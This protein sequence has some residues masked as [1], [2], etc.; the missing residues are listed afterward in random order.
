KKIQHAA[1]QI[2]LGRFHLQTALRIKRRQVVKENLVA[3]DF[4][5]LKIDGFDF[6]QREI[7]FAV[8][9]RAH[10]AGD[11]VAGAQV[12]LADLRRG[13]VD[14][15][16]PGKIVVFRSAQESESIGQ[17]FKDALGENQT[18]LF[19]LRA[20]DLKDQ[21]LLAHAARAGNVQFLG[22]LG[23]VG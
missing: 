10:L 20:E 6:D 18:V 1:G 4:R 21:L 19:R 8:F 15:V 2:F 5:V 14:I 22:N 9:R 11:G 13:N 17:A 3:R 7:A 23:E 12:K 16:R